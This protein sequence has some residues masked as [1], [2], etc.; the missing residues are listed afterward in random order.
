MAQKT[1][2]ARE[3][4]SEL[5]GTLENMKANISKDADSKEV[6]DSE[7]AS[8]AYVEGFALRVFTMA[9]EEDRAGNATR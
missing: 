7:A 2:A 6:I 1:A 9:D 4:L 5:L 3:F 8:A